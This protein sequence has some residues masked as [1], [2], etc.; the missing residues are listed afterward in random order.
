MSII[1]DRIIRAILEAARGCQIPPF[2]MITTTS[3]DHPGARLAMKAY[4]GMCSRKRIAVPRVWCGK[5]D[6]HV[7]S[8]LHLARAFSYY[9][10]DTFG[11]RETI[12]VQMK[13]PLKNWFLRFARVG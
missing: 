8:E 4:K 5:H 6:I 1:F 3:V 10:L 2:I 7:T 12:K 13:V 9:I 11:Q